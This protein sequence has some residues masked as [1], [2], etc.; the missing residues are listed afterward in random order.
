VIENVAIY[1]AKNP[2][3]AAQDH[4]MAAWTR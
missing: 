2:R 3:Y 1:R 4:P